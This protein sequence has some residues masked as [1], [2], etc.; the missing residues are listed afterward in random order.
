KD[1]PTKEKFHEIM[2]ESGYSPDHPQKDPCYRATIH[3][4]RNFRNQHGLEFFYFNLTRDYQYNAG[5]VITQSS[6]NAPQISNWFD[7]RESDD[8][9]EDCEPSGGS[10]NINLGNRELDNLKDK[11][12]ETLEKINNYRYCQGCKKVF[13]DV[14]LV[15][16]VHSLICPKCMLFN[17]LKSITPESN[18]FRCSVCE[19]LKFVYQKRS[20]KHSQPVCEKCEYIIGK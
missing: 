16:H 15:E 5:K 11:L 7:N 3:I 10:I 20:N 9:H 12:K 17:A 19:N 14:R 8:I 4:C 6:L 2:K 1:Q 18:K 13:E